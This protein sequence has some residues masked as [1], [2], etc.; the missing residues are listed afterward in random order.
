MRVRHVR[1]R[2]MRRR[3]VRHVG[4]VPMSAVLGVGKGRGLATAVA[5]L[6]QA[7]LEAVVR[8]RR[9]RVTQMSVPVMAVYQLSYFRVLVGDVVAELRLLESGGRHPLIAAT[10]A[11][12]IR[13]V[14]AGLDELLARLRGD[15]RLQL[16]R[17]KCVHVARL[18]G[19]QQH[20][21]RP[22]QRGQL[23]GLQAKRESRGSC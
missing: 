8:G 10:D 17:G 19:H 11:G 14:E 1:M 13:R 3:H 18:A 4:V 9:R 5:R 6:H 16:A 12:R 15:H 23:V 2:R 21:L 20:H 7:L 22:G